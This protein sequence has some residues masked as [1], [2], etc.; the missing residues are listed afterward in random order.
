MLGFEGSCKG[1]VDSYQSPPFPVS[2]RGNQQGTEGQI[3]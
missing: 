1:R 3:D 2:S